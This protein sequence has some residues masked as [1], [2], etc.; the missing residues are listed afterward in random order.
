MSKAIEDLE[1]E[2]EVIASALTIIDRIVSRI[3]RNERVE[4]PDLQNFVGFLKEFADKCHH[5]KE[6]GILFPALIKAG[7]P[8]KGG[9]IEAM[10]QEH[11]LGRSLVV[12][13]ESALK[14]TPNLSGFGSAADRYSALLR[15]HIQKENQVLFPR[16]ERT[17]SSARLDTIYDA[18]EEHERKVIGQ[19]RHEALHTML[20]GLESKYPA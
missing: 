6:E 12:E 5:G 14:G 8:V 4:L 11:E 20:K 18:F 7:M 9:P 2:H 1:H 10:L 15:E 19:G 13:M 17:L 16:A 3:R